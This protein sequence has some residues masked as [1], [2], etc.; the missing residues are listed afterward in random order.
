MGNL[1][2]D[3]RAFR[4]QRRPVDNKTRG[5][6]TWQRNKGRNVSWRNGPRRESQG[7]TTEYSSVCPNVTGRTNENIVQTKRARVGSLALVD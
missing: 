4:Y 1:L 7:W 6:D 5:N 2:D 3:L